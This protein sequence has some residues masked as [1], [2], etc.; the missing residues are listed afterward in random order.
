MTRDD[1]LKQLADLGY[2]ITQE[3]DNLV[4]FPFTVPVGKFAGRPIRLAFLVA[5]DVGLNP[6]PGP[7]I[8]PPLLPFKP[9][10][11]VHPHDGVHPSPLGE[12]WQYWSR[13]FTGWAKTDRSARSYMGHINVLF[14]TQ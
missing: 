12:G 14:D 3:K 5:G 10:A 13:P 11:G 6:P 9:H 8:S 2:E 1:F 7:H 4:S